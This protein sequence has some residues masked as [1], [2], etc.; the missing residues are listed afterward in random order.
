[1]PARA[2]PE[3]AGGA[4]WV[5]RVGEIRWQRVIGIGILS[6]LEYGLNERPPYEGGAG[7]IWTGQEECLKGLW[8]A[9]PK[10]FFQQAGI[11]R[12]P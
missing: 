6:L 7:I 2:G 5:D 10:S 11:A 9:R 1:M 12:A 4:S 3:R 8:R